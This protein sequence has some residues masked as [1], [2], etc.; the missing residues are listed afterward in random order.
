M[1]VGYMGQL[2]KQRTENG[3]WNLPSLQR[4]SGPCW[5][6]ISIS[7]HAQNIS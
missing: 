6:C 7:S 4:L 1:K 5:F 2:E 3:N